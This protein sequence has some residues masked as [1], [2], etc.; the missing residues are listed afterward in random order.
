MA[1]TRTF[2]A[3]GGQGDAYSQAV[4]RAH[5]DALS[6]NTSY[7]VSGFE[8]HSAGAGPDIDGHR[9]RAWVNGFLIDQ[10]TNQTGQAVSASNTNFVFLNPD[11]TLE[12]ETMGS[13]TDSDALLIGKCVAD[14]SSVTSITHRFD[15]VNGHNVCIFKDSSEAT[16][17]DDELTWTA[18]PREI[19]DVS[20]ILIVNQTDAAPNMKVGPRVPSGYGV[21]LSYGPNDT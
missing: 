21:N 4:L 7:V 10:T 2:K 5:Y 20:T 14:G 8:L 9:G 6:A 16:P 19:W 18:N 13:P 3:E 17:G 15:I 1:T 12:I 11:G